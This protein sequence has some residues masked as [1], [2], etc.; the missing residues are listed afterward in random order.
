MKKDLSNKSLITYILIS[1]VLAVLI[2]VYFNFLYLIGVGIM[3][4]SSGLFII[5]AD[6]ED[7]RW[8]YTGAY[9][10]VI[11]AIILIAGLYFL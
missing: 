8:A 2:G 11:G 9:C 1:T 6:Q 10:F 3:C 5:S 7:S 4:A